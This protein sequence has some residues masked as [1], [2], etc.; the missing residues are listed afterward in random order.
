MHDKYA[1]TKVVDGTK[2]LFRCQEH[3]LKDVTNGH[4]HLWHSN[5]S[6]CSHNQQLSTS[7]SIYIF[8]RQKFSF[9]QST[10]FNVYSFYFI[11]KSILFI[12]LKARGS[13]QVDRQLSAGRSCLILHWIDE[14]PKKNTF[15][16][17]FHRVGS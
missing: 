12:H 4:F 2:R 13:Q 1:L 8:N 6:S 11:A 5:T 14:T 17:I 9:K 7:S 15:Q 16:S 10:Y 3:G